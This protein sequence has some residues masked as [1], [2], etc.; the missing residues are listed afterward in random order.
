[1]KKEMKI[2]LGTFIKHLENMSR[3]HSQKKDHIISV[4][5]KRIWI[6]NT[7]T[8]KSWFI[9]MSTNPKNNRNTKKYH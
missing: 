5:F 1:M 3:K 6:L 4:T 2:F 8:I 9:T 7:E